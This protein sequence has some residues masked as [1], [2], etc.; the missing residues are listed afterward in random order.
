MSIKDKIT[1]VDYQQY[2]TYLDYLFT[3]GQDELNKIDEYTNTYIIGNRGKADSSLC[4][5]NGVIQYLD[6]LGNT[7]KVNTLSLK[8]IQVGLTFLPIDR[9]NDLDEFYQ[10]NLE[11][12][13]IAF[14]TTQEQVA[15]KLLLDSKRN[16]TKNKSE[17]V[18]KKNDK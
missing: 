12:L 4:T 13:A 3:S 18:I 16:I 5:R 10:H 14:G 7:E 6:H 15:M 8:V 2:E 9:F 17:I 11:K 1:I